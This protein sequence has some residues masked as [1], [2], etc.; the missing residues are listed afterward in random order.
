MGSLQW[1][2]AISVMMVLLALGCMSIIA[3]AFA[4]NRTVR[5]LR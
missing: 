1:G 2:G 5:E 3:M 4:V